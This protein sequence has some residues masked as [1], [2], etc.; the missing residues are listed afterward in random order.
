MIELL[1]RSTASSRHE[2]DLVLPRDV[3]LYRFWQL[4]LHMLTRHLLLHRGS[5]TH[6]KIPQV[7]MRTLKSV[8]VPANNALKYALLTWLLSEVFESV[9]ALFDIT[10]KTRVRSAPS[11][12]R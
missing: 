6:Q 5:S 10:R 9:R 7:M 8:F 4:R 3:V 11:R 2:C 12:L 1:G